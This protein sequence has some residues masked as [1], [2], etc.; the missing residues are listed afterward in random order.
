MDKIS[1]LKQLRILD[2]SDI[3]PEEQWEA[4]RNLSGFFSLLYKI[5]QRLKKEGKLK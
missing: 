5:D 1:N 4:S 2:A 3:R